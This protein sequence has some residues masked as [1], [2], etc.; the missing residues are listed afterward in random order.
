MSP[1]PLSL[2]TNVT[3]VEAR[4]D[5]PNESIRTKLMAPQERVELPSSCPK[6]FPLPHTFLFEPFL[7]FP[8][9]SIVEMKI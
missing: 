5:I 7:N 6:F 9:V 3:S 1:V 8:W 4:P 2:G